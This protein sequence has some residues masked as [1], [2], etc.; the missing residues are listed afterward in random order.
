MCMYRPPKTNN[1]F[2]YE[3]YDLLSFMAFRSDKLMILRDLNINICCPSKP[4]VSEFL[5]LVK[6]FN[7]IQSVLAS[8]H[9]KGHRLD[10]SI[11][12]LEVVDIN[13]FDH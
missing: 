10:L 5:L 6:S 2:I 8:P 7:L 4:R 13:I 1:N 11:S 9:Q 3:F 12:N